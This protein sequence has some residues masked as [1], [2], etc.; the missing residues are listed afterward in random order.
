MELLFSK[1]VVNRQVLASVKIL[2]ASPTEAIRHLLKLVFSA[3]A[4]ALCK[5]DT[6][7]KVPLCEVGL[8]AVHGK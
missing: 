7:D 8:E 6:L 4:L 2:S 5:V 1:V 3:D